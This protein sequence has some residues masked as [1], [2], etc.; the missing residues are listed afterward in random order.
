MKMTANEVVYVIYLEGYTS[1]EQL[2]E[3]AGW[4]VEEILDLLA[5]IG[6]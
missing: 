2:A 1:A 6:E 3:K 5:E 4:T